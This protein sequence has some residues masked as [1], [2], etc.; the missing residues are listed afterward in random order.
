MLGADLPQTA[1]DE[2]S[3]KAFSYG[4]VSPSD[5]LEL[6]R[7]AKDLTRKHE[8][9]PH[10][11]AEEFYKLALDCGIY[12]GHAISIRDAVKEIR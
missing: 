8:L 1:I 6:G 5:A 3:A 9:A 4:H 11:A 7:L 12:Q 2:F 10:D